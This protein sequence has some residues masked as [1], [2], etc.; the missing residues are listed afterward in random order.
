MTFEEARDRV[1]EVKE[2]ME[3]DEIRVDQILAALS[4]LALLDKLMRELDWKKI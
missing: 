1:S 4:D 2:K 3:N